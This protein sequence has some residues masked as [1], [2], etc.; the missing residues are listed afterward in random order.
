MV[1]QTSV[2]RANLINSQV[3]VV[4]A[5]VGAPDTP[6]DPTKPAIALERDRLIPL[7]RW[8][9]AGQEWIETRKTVDSSTLTP[10]SGAVTIPT[11]TAIFNVNGGSFSRIILP[12]LND[13]YPEPLLVVRSLTASIYTIDGF[14]QTLNPTYPSLVFVAVDGAWRLLPFERSE[15]VGSGIAVR[16]R[17]YEFSNANFTIPIDAKYVRQTGSM[18]A[19]RVLTLPDLAPAGTEIVIENLGQNYGGLIPFHLSSAQSI[20]YSDS[21]FKSSPLCDRIICTKTAT[22]W[23]IS[24]QLIE[25]TYDQIVY[26]KQFVGAAAVNEQYFSSNGLGGSSNINPTN[27]W[28]NLST[29]TSATGAIALQTGSAIIRANSSE[30]LL[31]FSRVYVPILSDSSQRYFAGVGFS[32]VTFNSNTSS[33]FLIRYSDAVNGGRW[34]IRHGAST[35]IDTGV[36]VAANTWFNLAIF[37]D[38]SN[39]YYFVNGSLVSTQSRVL[40]A[41]MAAG[42]WIGKSVGT[43]LREFRCRAITASFPVDLIAV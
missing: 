11:N 29:S 38:V 28:A 27:G 12:L 13:I 2:G 39:V 34:E 4:A 43:T 15:G 35:A 41:A 9:V 21:D 5:G 19:A 32:T 37:A 8:D 36:L 3:A 26:R 24:E 22:G 23:K 31:I 16:D 10:A 42:V 30:P 6:G 25:S 18:T 17:V 20:N 40:L 1:R 14:N 7:Y 33:G